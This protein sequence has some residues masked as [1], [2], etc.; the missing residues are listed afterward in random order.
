MKKINNSWKAES[1]TTVIGGGRKK[2]EHLQHKW[3]SMPNAAAKMPSR[4]Q[5]WQG[6]Y[7]ICEGYTKAWN[8]G[9]LYLHPPS[10]HKHTHDCPFLSVRARSLRELTSCLLFPLLPSIPVDSSQTMGLFPVRFLATVYLI[11]QG[12]QEAETKHTHTHQQW[13][14]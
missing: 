7:G 8:D 1:N 4:L 13:R 9:P 2:H 11:S 5:C 3:M 6:K 14:N 12:Q 10:L